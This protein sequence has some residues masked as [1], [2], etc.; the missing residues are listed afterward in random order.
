VANGVGQVTLLL[1]ESAASR[2]RRSNG[3]SG[4]ILPMAVLQYC[5]SKPSHWTKCEYGKV[6]QAGVDDSSHIGSTER[7]FC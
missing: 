4:R 3:V 7:C 2:L 1:R 5:R 6:G